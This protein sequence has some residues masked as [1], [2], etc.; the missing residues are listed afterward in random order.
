MSGKYGTLFNKVNIAEE[1]IAH[2]LKMIEHLIE[3]SLPGKIPAIKL[4][5]KLTKLWFQKATDK[6]ITT[7]SLSIIQKTQPKPSDKHTFRFPILKT[8]LST[9]LWVL[10]F[11]PTPQNQHQQPHSK[12]AES[13]NVEANHLG[14]AKSLF[15]HYC[16]HLRLNHNQI[17]AESVFNF[18]VNKK[19]AYLLE[20]LINKEIKHYTQQ[21]YPITYASKGKGKLQTL[22]V[23]PQWIQPSTWKKH[24]IELPTNPSYHYTPKSAINIASTGTSTSNVTSTFG[25]FLFQNFRIINPWEPTELEEKKEESEDQEFTYQNLITKNPD[26]ETQNFQTQQDQNLKN[27]EIKTPPNQNNQNPDLINQQNLPPNILQPPIQQ[28]QLIAP[29]AFALITKLEKF[30][31][32]EDDTQ[33]WI[34]NV[35]KA[36]TANN[37]DNTRTIQ[38]IPYFLKDTANSCCGNKKCESA[39]TVVNKVTLDLLVTSENA[40]S[41]K[42]ETKQK[43]LTS[44]IPLAASIEDK[45]LAA[46]FPFELEGI[47][48][49]PLFSGAILDTKPITAMYTDAKVDVDRA[50]NT[51]IITANRATKTPIGEIDDFSFEVNGIIVPIKILVMEATQYQALVS[52]DW[53]IKTNTIFDWTIQELQLSQNGQ[54]THVPATYGHFKTIN[55]SILLIEFE[56]KEKKP[57]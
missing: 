36:I 51:K 52:N 16:Q 24:R 26:I 8:A 23:T 57:I 43:P 45:S 55:M 42:P 6:T 4:R 12:V 28:Q 13:E 1:I 10:L 48:L 25:R 40:A 5:K 11:T 50:A 33:A 39:T 32:E 56:E 30:I 37:W 38:V 41:S 20:T 9:T 44:N 54:H 21:R 18:Y 15:Q 3:D 46:I 14:F 27:P 2:R 31:G 29:M 49:I 19:I 22:A 53:L 34:N 17:S 35:T 7:E 47:T